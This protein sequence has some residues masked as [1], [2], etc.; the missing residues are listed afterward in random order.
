MQRPWR[1]MVALWESISI[2]SWSASSL[3]RSVVLRRQR[4]AEIHFILSLL[5][6][7]PA[8]FASYDANIKHDSPSLRNRS[9]GISV[10][11]VMKRQSA[12]T[13]ATP[14]WRSLRR[15]FHPL[16]PRKRRKSAL[17]QRSEQYHRQQDGAFVQPRHRGVHNCKLKPNLRQ[18]HCGQGRGS[19]PC[20]ESWPSVHV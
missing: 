11:K 6:L 9:L 17:E 5:A 14:A 4:S 18:L 1:A 20:C 16:D 13:Y 2:C 12:P 7:A 10:P 3:L 19:A 8:A 15:L